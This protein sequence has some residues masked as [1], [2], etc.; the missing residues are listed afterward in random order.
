MSYKDIFQGLIISIFTLMNCMLF[1]QLVMYAIHYLHRKSF[2]T[3][4][5]RNLDYL[6]YPSTQPPNLI[7][8]LTTSHPPYNIVRKHIFYILSHAT[9]IIIHL[10]IVQHV[11][12]TSLH[13]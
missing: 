4:E 7:L 8:D 13:D 6:P 3:T 11:R 5:S 1:V 10:G 2:K 9:Y 12:P